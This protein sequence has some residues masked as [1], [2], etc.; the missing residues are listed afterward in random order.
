MCI[1]KEIEK[2]EQKIHEYGHNFTVVKKDEFKE[3]YPNLNKKLGDKS[4]VKVNN[5]MVS[6]QILWDYKIIAVFIDVHYKRD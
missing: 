3:L 6:D 5:L 1:N 2:L 4:Y